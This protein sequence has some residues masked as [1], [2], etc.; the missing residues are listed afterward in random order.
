[1]TTYAGSSQ[2]NEIQKR[3]ISLII[4]LSPEDCYNYFINDVEY[5]W[6]YMEK[7]EQWGILDDE[8][9]VRKGLEDITT[10]NET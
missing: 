6:F 7:L 2:F 5:D 8:D 10:D 3:S 4:N 1:L 9:I